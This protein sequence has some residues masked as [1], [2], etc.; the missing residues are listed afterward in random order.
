M[1]L[2]K[3]GNKQEITNWRQYQSYYSFQKFLRKLCISNYMDILCHWDSSDGD[4]IDSAE[5]Y[6]REQIDRVPGR[7]KVFLI[8]DSNAK[9]G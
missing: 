1:P 9:V 2:H 6:L 7:N 3:G 8:G 4:S 5:F